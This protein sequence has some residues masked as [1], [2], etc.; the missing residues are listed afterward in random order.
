MLFD[1]PEELQ[2]E[3]TLTYSL[4]LKDVKGLFD[5]IRIQERLCSPYCGCA[6]K[7]SQCQLLYLLTSKWVDLFSL[8]QKV[9]HQTSTEM[10]LIGRVDYTCGVPQMMDVKWTV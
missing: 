9:P 4:N 2:Y 10:N 1:I 5:V 3:V 8:K 7:H 6:P